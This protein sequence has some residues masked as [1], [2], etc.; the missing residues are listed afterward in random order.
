M[1][2]CLLLPV[3][4]ISTTAAFR[5]TP[6]AV[7][8]NSNGKTHLAKLATQSAAPTHDS[9]A[10]A[11]LAIGVGLAT[12]GIAEPAF[13]SDV[14]WIGTTKPLLQA[15]LTIGT[16]AFLFRT[17]LSWFPKYDL[18]ELPWSVIAILTEPFLKPTR[19]VVPPVAGVDI[20]PIIW[21]SFLSFLSEI[22]CGPQGLLTIMQKKGGM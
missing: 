19:A 18:K 10:A 3:V 1:R 21:V 7:P 15:F 16:V 17:V 13:A 6:P 11:T 12:M 22:L 2:S 9:N 5:V 20:S 4:A 14:A 8:K